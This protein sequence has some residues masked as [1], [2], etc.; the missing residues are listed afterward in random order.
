MKD[1]LTNYKKHKI[2]QNI[3]LVISSLVLA[4]AI[5]IFIIDSDNIQFLKTNVLES[6]SSYN[7][8]DIYLEKA[9]NQEIILKN[10]KSMDNV[11]SISFSLFFDEDALTIKN[12]SPQ[13]NGDISIISQSGGI[14]Q[15]IVSFDSAQDLTQNTEFARISTE[16][17][18]EN[19]VINISS[20]QFY[21]LEDKSY[22][23]SSSGIH[24]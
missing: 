9:E 15:Y 23:L 1:I 11:K 24:F 22:L 18:Q 2:F 17:L 8:S 7:N 3:F 13:A 21:D 16:K 4:I 19:A 14:A 10:S 12:I 20:A 5:H 6:S